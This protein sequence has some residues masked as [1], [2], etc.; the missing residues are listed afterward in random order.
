MDQ[1]AYGR[2]EKKPS[3]VVTSYHWQ[4]M[5]RHIGEPTGRPAAHE[6]GGTGEQTVERRGSRRDHLRAAGRT[7]STDEKERDGGRL[8]EGTSAGGHSGANE[9][10]GRAAARHQEKVP[11]RGRKRLR[12]E[13][14]VMPAAA[15]MVTREGN[16]LSLTAIEE[17]EDPHT[18]GPF[19][20][21]WTADDDRT[22]EAA[23]VEGSKQRKRAQHQEDEGVR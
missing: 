16:E 6:Q 15:P 20:E 5:R 8:G 17:R 22:R 19:G 18:Q 21:P 4:P 23:T 1:C 9:T 10:S 14:R 2:G 12:D 13:T 7:V 3:I 11:D